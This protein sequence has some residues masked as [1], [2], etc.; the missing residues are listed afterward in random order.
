MQIFLE[1][2]FC[3]EEEEGRTVLMVVLYLTLACLFD[4]AVLEA[5]GIL[6]SLF[7]V[8]GRWRGALLGI[9]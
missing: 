6:G 3:D 1:K 4:F 7:V 9:S 8:F 2:E 5:V